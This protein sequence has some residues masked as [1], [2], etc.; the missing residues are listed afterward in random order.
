MSDTKADC[1]AALTE[2]PELRILTDD[3]VC[4]LANFSK[5]TLHRLDLLGD[6]P[7]KVRLSARRHGRP[8]LGFRS[9]LESRRT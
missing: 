6:G 5:D 3:E 1:K 2:F 9:W 4:K 8:Y 7:P